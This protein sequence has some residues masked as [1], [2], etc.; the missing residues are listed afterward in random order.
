MRKL[1][2][3]N[4]FLLFP[5]LKIF[6]QAHLKD[7]QATSVWAPTDVKIDGKIN[8]WE[9]HF[10]AYNKRTK[11]ILYGV[12]IMI[13]TFSWRFN[14]VTD[15][16][17]N[18]KI[19]AGGITFTINTEGKKKDKNAFILTYPVISRASRGRGQRGGAADAASSQ[20]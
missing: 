3:F 11:V 14:T 18:A 7:V 20:R 4:V 19:T 6:A 2:L 8:E 13:N 9:D 15:A 10:Q 12:L 16:Q 17:N 1:I 5:G